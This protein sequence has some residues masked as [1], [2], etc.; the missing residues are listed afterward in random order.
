MK[1]LM[2]QILCQ[3]RNICVL[4]V[5][6]LYHGDCL[7]V[8][9]N[10]DDKSIDMILCDYKNGLSMRNIAKKYK[11]NHKLI[12]RILFKNN[13]ERRAKNDLSQIE[14]NSIKENIGDYLV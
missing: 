7:E 14:W 13:I 1:Y 4:E 12:G 5:N 10:I 2:N 6:N 11:T 3:K 9:K 8:M